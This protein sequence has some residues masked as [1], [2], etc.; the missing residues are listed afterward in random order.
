MKYV[1]STG[2]IIRKEAAGIL[3]LKKTQTVQILGGMVD[4]GVLL[5]IGAGRNTNY[6]ANV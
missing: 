6:V 3:S 5:K 4:K 2:R 1:K